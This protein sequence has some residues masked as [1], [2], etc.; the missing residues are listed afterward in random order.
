MRWP[1][2]RPVLEHRMTCKLSLSFPIPATD[3]LFRPKLRESGEE[4]EKVLTCRSIHH[5]LT[6]SML[7]DRPRLQPTIA[8]VIQEDVD[9]MHDDASPKLEGVNSTCSW[10][11]TSRTLSNRQICISWP[12]KIHQPHRKV[13]YKFSMNRMAGQ[14]TAA[15]TDFDIDRRG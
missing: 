6:L 4:N 11:L 10:A 15:V 5:G 14:P 2:R 3:C 9:T 1:C 8:S 7:C 13:Q 12:R